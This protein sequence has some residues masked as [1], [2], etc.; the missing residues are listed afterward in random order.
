MSS[1]SLFI[2]GLSWGTT[3]QALHNHVAAIAPVVSVKIPKDRISG[4]SR[5]F[6]FVEME[7]EDGA[8]RVRAELNEVELDGRALRINEAKDEETEPCKLYVAGIPDGVSD[9]DL[10]QYL[11]QYGSVTKVSIAYDRDTRR[12]RGFAFVDTTS[13]NDSELI[14]SGANGSEWRGSRLS[15]RKSRPKPIAGKRP[16]GHHHRG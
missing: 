11:A 10:L 14:I 12:S 6:A 7:S 1:R 15:V 8:Q 16:F 3:E 2:G 9:A 5:G 4:K 13:E